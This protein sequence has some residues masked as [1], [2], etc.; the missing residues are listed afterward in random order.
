MSHLTIWF[1]FLNCQNIEK[2]RNTKTRMHVFNEW[3][4]LFLPIKHAPKTAEQ[5]TLVVF[6][7]QSI[8]QIILFICCIGIS[9]FLLWELFMLQNK[10]FWFDFCTIITV[11]QAENHAPSHQ[12]HPFWCNRFA[13]LC[14]NLVVISP[15]S[16]F[17]TF[18]SVNL[19]TAHCATNAHVGVIFAAELL[20]SSLLLQCGIS[21]SAF[22]KLLVRA[23]NMQNFLVL[24]L[25]KCMSF[26]SSFVFRVWSWSKCSN[27]S[28]LES[29]TNK[30]E[31]KFFF[32]FVLCLIFCFKWTIVWRTLQVDALLTLHLTQMHL[33]SLSFDFAS[34]LCTSP[35]A[36]TQQLQFPLELAATCQSPNGLSK[37]FH[38]ICEIGSWI[39]VSCA[40]GP[41]KNL[42]QLW[43]LCGKQDHKWKGS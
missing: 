29:D 43:I 26:V 13:N 4:T 18:L 10:L 14:L 7:T 24:V 40:K 19:T 36:C 35:G 32:S 12:Q 33:D 34:N 31:K 15:R 3:N 25:N 21:F 42:P 11:Q 2:T 20:D 23:K 16:V 1:N 17:I 8:D 38:A 37:Q 6:W 9:A 22:L 41:Q 28:F 5:N 27:V 39:L 30:N